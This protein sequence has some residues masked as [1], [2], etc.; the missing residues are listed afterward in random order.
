M[1]PAPRTLPELASLAIDGERTL[2]KCCMGSSPFFGRVDFNKN[3]EER[4]GTVLEPSGIPVPYY[5]CGACGFL[6]TRF[7]DHWTQAEF[8]AHVYNAD[9]GQ[10]DPEFEAERPESWGKALSGLLGASLAQVSL[11]DWGG[12]NGRLA[13]SLRAQGILRAETWEPFNP[14]FQA[15]P[16]GEFNLVTCIEVLEHLPDPRAG[17][18]NLV[19]A[20]AGEG[21]LVI[22][23]VPQPADIEAVGAAWWYLAP[24]NGHIS[25]FTPKALELLLQEHGFGVVAPQSNVFFAWRAMPGFLEAVLPR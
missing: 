6:F 10:V 7:F 9:Y 15:R 1:A 21:A 16:E 17:I 5:R 20:L 8:Q 12:G 22:S 13:E 11:L 19:R 23:T 4:N 14:R 18:R 25:L 3:C 24:R 2:C